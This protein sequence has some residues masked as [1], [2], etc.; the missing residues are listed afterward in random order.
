MTRLLVLTLCVVPARVFYAPASRVCA[1]AARPR[2]AIGRARVPLAQIDDDEAAFR[3]LGIGPDASYDEIMDSFEELSERYGGD[4][5]RIAALE[6]AKEK[7]LDLRLRQRMAGAK[8]QYSGQL[9]VEDVKAPPKTPP[10]VIAND[11]RKKV[12]EMPTPRYALKVVGLMGG[13]ALATWVA[14][15]T[16]GTILLVNVVGGMGFTYNRGEPDVPR[17]D[18][19]QIGEIR[20]MKPRPFILTSAI[21]L[22]C[23]IGGYV[24]AKQVV[25]AAAAAT[26]AAPR[27]LE[28]V[29]RTTFISAF[30]M[31]PALFLK[32]QAVFDD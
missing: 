32:V 5:A 2:V 31:I 28:V 3:E 14:P 16:S 9:S 27:G 29:L 12:I 6:G 24:K 15:S 23:W 22:L 25:A 17:D 7:V 26:G 8:A 4:P 10:W 18:F 19:G 30:L 13:L 11:F 20:P 21:A 1:P